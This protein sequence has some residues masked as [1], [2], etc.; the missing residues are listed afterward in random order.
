MDNAFFLVKKAEI[1]LKTAKEAYSKWLEDATASLKRT[2]NPAAKMERINDIVENEKV[3]AEIIH[4]AQ[5]ELEMAQALY[6]H[7]FGNERTRRA[8]ANIII[9]GGNYGR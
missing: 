6:S 5:Q 9:F 7:K 1:K 4:D 3:Y 8:A 2:T